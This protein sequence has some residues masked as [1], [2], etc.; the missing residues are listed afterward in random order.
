MDRKTYQ[1]YLHSEVWK[2]KKEK[3]YSSK[4]P[5]QCYICNSRENLEIHHRSYKR[6]GG[7]EYLR[8]L[9]PLCRHHHRLIHQYLKVGK[10]L[11]LTRLNTWNVAKK[12]R[13]RLKKNLGPPV[14]A[15]EQSLSALETWK[16]TRSAKEQEP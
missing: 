7:S 13:K 11:G 5:K 4:L 8:D 1:K 12:F 16:K 14:E 10:K 3:Y 15:W 6:V 2:E 9:L